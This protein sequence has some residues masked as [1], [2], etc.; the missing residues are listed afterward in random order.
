MKNKVKKDRW[1]YIFPLWDSYATKKSVAHFWQQQTFDLNIH[2]DH[3]NCD[4]CFLK[5]LKKKGDGSLS[6]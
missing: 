3:G 4:F 5:G 1:E 2:S 6:Y